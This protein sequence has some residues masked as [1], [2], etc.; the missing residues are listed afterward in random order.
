MDALVVFISKPCPA[1]IIVLRFNWLEHK[2]DTRLT[3]EMQKNH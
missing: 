1:A 2:R 3:P